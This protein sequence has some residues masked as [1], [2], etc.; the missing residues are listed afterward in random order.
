M[1]FAHLI[2]MVGSTGKNYIMT[3]YSNMGYIIISRAEVK[4]ERIMNAMF[5]ECL[6]YRQFMVLDNINRSFESRRPWLTRAKEQGYTTTII[7]LK[8]SERHPA[9]TKI[10]IP[11]EC[12][13]DELIVIDTKNNPS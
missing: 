1:S 12:E 7:Y 11:K 3:D 8:E 2:V 5:E 10:Q 6:R 9:L 4:S 13:A